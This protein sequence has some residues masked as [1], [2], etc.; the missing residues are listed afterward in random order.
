MGSPAPESCLQGPGASHV[1]GVPVLPGRA[2]SPE[3][4]LKALISTG[5]EGVG[6][7]LTQEQGL[8]QGSPLSSPSSPLPPPSIPGLSPEA[9]VLDPFL[10]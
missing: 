3:V 2:M 8:H 9:T 10:P 6:A 5:A 4:L 7:W 1:L